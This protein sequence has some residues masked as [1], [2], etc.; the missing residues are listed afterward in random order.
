M[1]EKTTIE[2]GTYCQFRHQ[3]TQESVLLWE[4]IGR[5]QSDL[6]AEDQISWRWTSDG[7]YMTHSASLIQFMGDSNELKISPIWCTRG[8]PKCC[9]FR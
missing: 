1:P 3:Q 7:V 5:T 9:F 4:A 8:E 2:S 6:E